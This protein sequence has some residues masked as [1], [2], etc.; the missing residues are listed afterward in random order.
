MDS[1]GV[2][3]SDLR[4]PDLVGTTKDL[5]ICLIR[6]MPRFFASLRMTGR[7]RFSAASQADQTQL[8][9]AG[10]AAAG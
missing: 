1:I 8:G 9:R 5:R 6:Q 4:S 2:L 3:K 10:A 7:E